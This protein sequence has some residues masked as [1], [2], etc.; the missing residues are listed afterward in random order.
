M[1]NFGGLMI[2][3]VPITNI[4]GP[5][6][7]TLA[8]V[9]GIQVAGVDL[10]TACL[11]LQDGQALGRNIGM[12][13]ASADMS[14]IF[15]VPSGT[16]PINGGSYS[17]NANSGTTSSV[18]SVVFT[19]NSGGWS[20]TKTQSPN[21]GGGTIA[22]GSLPTGAVTA[23]FTLTVTSSTTSTSSSNSAPTNTTISSTTLSASVQANATPSSPERSI[24][25]TLQ[26]NYLNSSGTNISQTNLTMT[27]NATGA[28]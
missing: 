14:A 5:P 9:T 6:S 2:A 17:A 28:S 22:S 8:A 1:A 25:A 13:K 23:Q 4:Y 3:G 27:A 12:A 24:T 18:A 10:N 20:L 26:I 11:R 7:G 21:G 19:M 15:G 16:L